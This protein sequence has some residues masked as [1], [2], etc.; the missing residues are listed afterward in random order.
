[1]TLSSRERALVMASVFLVLGYVGTVYVL[2][3]FLES[4]QVVREQIEVQ[5]VELLSLRMLASERGRY[6]RRIEDLRVRVAE[7]ES[8]LLKE[9]KIPV[10]AAEVQERIH[11][12]GQETGVSIVR[13]SVLRPKDHEQFVEIPV[14]LSVKG[15]F[16]EIHTFLYKVEMNEKLLTVP[17][18]VIRS[19]TSSTGA[20]S[21]D[22]HIAGHIANG[23]K[24]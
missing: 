9:N 13:E 11:Q 2:D 19:P 7:A 12:F 18:F 21:L 16:R 8:V 14:E 1:M 5:R 23:G 15:S 20:L 10:V 22:L 17:Q 4:Q 24:L 3:P 6:Q